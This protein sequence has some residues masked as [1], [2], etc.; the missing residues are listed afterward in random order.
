MNAAAGTLRLTFRVRDGEVRLVS[1]ERLEMI[2]PPSIGELP[3]AGRNTGFWI[4]LRGAGDG[5]LCHRVLYSPLGD[6]VEVHSPDRNIRRVFGDVKENIF[7]LLMPDDRG[8]RNF[9]N[10]G[11]IHVE[12]VVH[13]PCNPIDDVKPNIFNTIIGGR[14]DLIMIRLERRSWNNYVN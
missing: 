10:S 14:T 13:R 5:G 2:Y 8:Y 4:A 9:P 12:D 3:Q 6:S 11:E 1:P 7:D